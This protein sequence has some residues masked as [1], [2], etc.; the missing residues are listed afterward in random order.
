MIPEPGRPHIDN[1]IA[2]LLIA[3]NGS[4]NLDLDTIARF[5]KF[6]PAMFRAR[7]LE[8]ETVWT[9]MPNNCEVPEGK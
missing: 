7:F 9:M 2:T 6:D 3:G 8:L 5:Q 4:R 1:L